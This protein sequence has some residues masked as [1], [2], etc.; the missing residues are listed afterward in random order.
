M[1]TEVKSITTK[2]LS[3]RQEKCETRFNGWKVKEFWEDFRERVGGHHRTDPSLC[4]RLQDNLGNQLTAVV[5]TGNGK[6]ILFCVLF[7]CVGWFSSHSTT[8]SLIAIKNVK[9]DWATSQLEWQSAPPHKLPPHLICP[10]ATRKSSHEMTTHK[11][12]PKVLHRSSLCCFACGSS[13]LKCTNANEQNIFGRPF[14]VC[15]K[16]RNFVYNMRVSVEREDAWSRWSHWYCCVLSFTR[17]IPSGR[18]RRKI[19][20]QSHCK[21]ASSRIRRWSAESASDSLIRKEF[22]CE[23][24]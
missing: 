18:G 7:G 8:C 12:T 15:E 2:N 22:A 9:S 14:G 17:S 11:L 23:C 6:Q 24:V 1:W 20:R 3:G 21:N 4:Y 16:I 5:V 10:N 13:C 19:S